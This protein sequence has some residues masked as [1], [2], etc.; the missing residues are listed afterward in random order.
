MA[1]CGLQVFQRIAGQPLQSAP[2]PLRSLNYH[3]G[4]YCACS[5]WY[6]YCLLMVE[7]TA[8]FSDQSQSAAHGLN[9]SQHV[10]G[11]RILKPLRRCKKIARRWQSLL[12]YCSRSL[13]LVCRAT[14]VSMVSRSQGRTVRLCHPSPQQSGMRI[15]RTPSACAR[16]SCVISAA[17]QRTKPRRTPRS[18]AGSL[19]RTR[20]CSG[21]H[22]GAAARGSAP[23][24]AEW[25]R[26][27]RR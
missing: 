26:P 6:N 27:R 8:L 15:P 25:S 18:R 3:T 10:V 14:R 24:Q 17:W 12:L 20:G 2:K 7:I 11:R 23:P 5:C 9:S 19:S 13:G 1:T 22:S 16:A 4:S 21:P